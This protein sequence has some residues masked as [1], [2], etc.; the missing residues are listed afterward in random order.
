[1]VAAPP[2]PEPPVRPPMSRLDAF[3]ARLNAQKL[4]LEEIAASIADVPG[5]VLELG[6]G[7]GRTFDHLR[8]ILPGR[9]IFVFDRAVSAHPA[10]IPDGEH[11]IVGEIRETLAFCGPRVKAPAAFVHCDLGTGDPTADLAKAEWL[12]PLITE[13]TASGRVGSERRGDEPAGV[14]GTADP[15]R[16]RKEPLPALPQAVR[17]VV[18]RSIPDADRHGGS[19][20]S[21]G[22]T[23]A[24]PPPSRG[25]V[26][27]GGAAN[28]AVVVSRGRSAALR[29]P[30]ARLILG[31]PPP[32]PPPRGGRVRVAF[33]ARSTD[34]LAP[35]DP[36][37]IFLSQLG[38]HP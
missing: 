9:E 17:G 20:V 38:A 18:I 14:R 29:A 11:M 32:Y 2:F 8:E 13:R 36:R 22:R 21:L 1:M 23:T 5:P 33:M 26:G 10:S 25:R 31:S 24:A 3:L 7:N 6:L 37:I 30:M 12:A 27:W 34:Y 4:L 35:S 15:P 19:G 28:S 16:P